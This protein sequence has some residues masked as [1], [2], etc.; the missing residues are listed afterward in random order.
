L[1]DAMQSADGHWCGCEINNI[2]RALRADGHQI[3]CF[4]SGWAIYKYRL[5][6]TAK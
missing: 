2:V 5:L 3:E 1:H 6:G 4:R